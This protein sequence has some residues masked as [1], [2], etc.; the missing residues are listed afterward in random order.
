MRIPDEN[1][2]AICGL[3]CGT[4][5]DYPE[6]CHGCLS[7]KL[8]GD[9]VACTPGFRTCAKEHG[10]KRCFA[11]SRFPCERLVAFSKV[12]IVNGIC[13]HENIITD[14]R[15]MKQTGV[16]N[17]VAAQTARHTCPQCGELMWW[18]E[19]PHVCKK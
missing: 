11:C 13:H 9:C 19:K 15:Q 4:C 16:E 3:F 5:P 2:A 18:C 10:V 7:D 12:H 1:T 17:W 6:N 8:R 14:L